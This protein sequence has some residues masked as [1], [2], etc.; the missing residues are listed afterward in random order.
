LIRFHAPNVSCLFLSAALLSACMSVPQTPV[1][2]PPPA[3][4]QATFTMLNGR[5][6]NVSVTIPHDSDAPECDKYASTWKSYVDAFTSAYALEWGTQ[7]GLRIGNETD[8]QKK[9]AWRAALL[10]PSPDQLMQPTTQDLMEMNCDSWFRSQGSGD[11][12]RQ[13]HNDLITSPPV[14]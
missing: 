5:T 9:T 1:Q 13:A 14:S 10:K 6:Q 3:V 2:T 7:V 12:R 11:G 4:T 8:P